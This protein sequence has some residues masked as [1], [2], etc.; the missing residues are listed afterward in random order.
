MR[1]Y[2]VAQP[3]AQLRR[4]LVHAL[5]PDLGRVHGSRPRVALDGR[6]AVLERQEMPGRE[7]ARLLEDRERRRD[8]VEGQ[9]RLERLGVDLAREAG[10]LQERLQLRAERQLHAVQP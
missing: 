3:V 4:E 5:A 6:A 10:L 1:A 2:R 9:E 7:L 8:R